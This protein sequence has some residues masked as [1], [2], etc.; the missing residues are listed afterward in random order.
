MYFDFKGLKLVQ[1]RTFG[2]AHNIAITRELN[3]AVQIIEESR[4]FDHVGARE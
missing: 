2:A 1:I 4:E 3:L